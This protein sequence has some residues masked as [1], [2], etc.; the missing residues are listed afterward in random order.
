MQG[1]SLTRP[2]EPSVA[3]QT[4]VA[5][6]A[7]YTYSVVDNDGSSVSQTFTIEVAGAV[8][9]ADAV[10]DQSYPRTHPIAP[11]VLPEAVGGAPPINYRL[12][13]TLPGGLEL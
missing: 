3:C 12:T 10:A 5:A 8:S 7:P 9:F 11:L 6:V 4:E 2:P 1:L 13:P